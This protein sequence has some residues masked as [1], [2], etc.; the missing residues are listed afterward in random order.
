MEGEE[1]GANFWGELWEEEG[2]K[3]EGPLAAE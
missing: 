1:E 2:C 3:A